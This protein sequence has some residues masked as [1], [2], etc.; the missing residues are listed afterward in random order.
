MIGLT[1]AVCLA[2]SPAGTASDSPA[3]SLP[4][5]DA[6]AVDQFWR[7][8]EAFEDE[9]YAQAVVAFE[10]AYAIE[11]APTLLFAIGNARRFAGDCPGSVDAL[12]RFLATEP[13]QD[14]ADDAR[15]V[16]ELCSPPKED[17][18]SAVA[19]PEPASSPSAKDTPRP[20]PLTISLLASGAVSLAAGGGLLVGAAVR[21]RQARTSSVH[22]DFL[23]LRAQGRVL[24]GV[25]IAAAAVGTALVV[26]GLLHRRTAR[27]RSAALSWT[28]DLGGV[29]FRF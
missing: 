7:G 19:G 29:T 22:Q 10:A 8:V 23:D 16:M 17:P 12:E 9:R 2:S 21:M 25:G 11:P 15:R 18:A 27:R 3:S 24:V 28:P 26:G 1:F 6:E 4:V 5:T 13:P 14:A 20:A